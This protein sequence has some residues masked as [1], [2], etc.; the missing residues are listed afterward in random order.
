M[1]IAE[2]YVSAL[3]AGGGAGTSEGT[4]WTFAE[5][6]TNLAAGQR[7]NVKADAAY[8]ITSAGDHSFTNSGSTDTTVF[9]IRGYTSTIGDGGRPVITATLGYFDWAFDTGAVKM[10]GIVVQDM[11]FKGSETGNPVLHVHNGSVVLNCT[12]ENT[13]AG[14]TDYVLHLEDGSAA[15]ACSVR[16]NSTTIGSAAVYCDNA[17]ASLIESAVK[18]KTLGVVC[19]KGF[20]HRSLVV[21]DGTGDAGVEF[22]TDREGRVV[23]C[24][25]YNFDDLILITAAPPADKNRL[26]VILNCVLYSG[27]NG[28]N[29]ADTE[30]TKVSITKCFIGATTGAQFSGLGDSD[31]QLTVTL[32][33]NPF[34][35]TGTDDFSL[36]EVA[37]GGALVRD[38]ALQVP[39]LL[40]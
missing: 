36:N 29:N 30:K 23:E 27:I 35:N 16:C 28:I 3:A 25:I 11:E 40:P 14:F 20:V 38:V 12:V 39:A 24:T 22:E 31:P 7:A 8:S 26:T 32:T 6:L 19:N 21:G 18:S 4:A 9:I 2:R 13:A 37:G 10:N 33:A 15:I 34:V 17:E 5:M 1:A